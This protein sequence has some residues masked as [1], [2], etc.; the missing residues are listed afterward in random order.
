METI[1]FIIGDPILIVFG[2]LI[3]LSNTF[4][5]LSLHNSKNFN[6]KLWMRI[7]LIIPPI[8]TLFSLV[9]LKIAAFYYLKENFVKYFKQ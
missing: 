1:N 7:L 9:I 5:A 2:I 8:A 4:T 6:L 3:V